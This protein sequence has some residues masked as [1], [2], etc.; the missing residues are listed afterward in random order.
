ML[1]FYNNQLNFRFIELMIILLYLIK[2]IFLQLFLS[3]DLIICYISG[4]VFCLNFGNC[5][6]ADGGKDFST[7]NFFIVLLLLIVALFTY[8]TI[9]NFNQHHDHYF[10]VICKSIILKGHHLKMGK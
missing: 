7:L 4:P 5:R 8:K 9:E 2:P 3:L 10:L 6:K 1:Q